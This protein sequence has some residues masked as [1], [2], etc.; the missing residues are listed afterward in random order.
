MLLTTALCCLL[1]SATPQAAPEITPPK[2]AQ[3]I[4]LH[5]GEGKQLVGKIAKETDDAVFLDIGF[6]VLKV[7]Q[8]RIVRR[9]SVIASGNEPVAEAGGIYTR[10]E[11]P[12]VSIKE[13]VDRVGEAV[14]KIETS[15]GQGSGF[16]TSADGYIATNFHVVEGE[17][18]A[19]VTLY[20]R[21]KNGFDVRTVQDVK[22]VAI[23]PHIDLALLKMD[24]P[25]DVKLSH[26]YIGDSEKVKAGDR[27]Y[28]IG[29]PIG[30][31]RSV[32]SGIVSV[33]N[34][35]Y[36][37]TPHFQITAAI[38]PGNSG[39]PLFN[40]RSEVIGVANAKM[41]GIGIEG[42][43]FAIP[44]KHLIDFLKNRDAFAF[45]ST[46]S[47][48]GIHYLPAPRKPRKETG[49]RQQEPPDDEDDSNSFVWGAGISTRV[50][51]RERIAFDKRRFR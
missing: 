15:T 40:L 43:N 34:R 50:P 17:I 9:E 27:V 21:S 32:S 41:V 14:V 35:S 3:D 24:P 16:I 5:L 2:S 13:G 19:D 31:E 49:E 48:N 45:D 6:D 37:G 46:R 44:G 47:E 4:I 30:L 8:T 10:A 39:G 25:E 28:A 22:V 12:E 38:N 33:T 11:L 36:G 51:V 29:T 1:Q 20:L 26:V 42:L 7:P 23:N 18:T